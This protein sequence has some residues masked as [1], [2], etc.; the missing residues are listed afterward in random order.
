MT[1]KEAVKVLG[2]WPIPFHRRLFRNEVVPANLG[3]RGGPPG[4]T[5]Q[6]VEDVAQRWAN[7]SWGQ[8]VRW[9]LSVWSDFV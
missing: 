4:V 8:K 6:S 1:V 9:V 2:R 5:R 7:A 3:F